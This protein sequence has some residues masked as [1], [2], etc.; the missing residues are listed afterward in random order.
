MLAFRHIVHIILS[1]SMFALRSK[2]T[3]FKSISMPIFRQI[4]TLSE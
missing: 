3:Y 1:A 2:D 4:V